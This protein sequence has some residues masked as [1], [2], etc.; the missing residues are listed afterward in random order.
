MPEFEV[1]GEEYVATPSAHERLEAFRI[2]EEPILRFLL[3]VV[4]KG[5]AWATHLPRDEFNIQK[6]VPDWVSD[7][8]FE[9]KALD[10]ARR[11]LI[12]CCLCGCRGDYQITT[13]GL[14]TLGVDRADEVYG[15]FGVSDIG[16]GS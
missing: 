1:M 3:D 6:A 5:G 16:G 9:V 14:E 8:L 13:R 2:E 7:R 11:G 10:M 12:D 4:R 15:S